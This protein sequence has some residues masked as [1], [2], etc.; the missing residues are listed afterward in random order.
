MLKPILLKI[1]PIAALWTSM[2]L[3]ANWP[4][5]VK[6]FAHVVLSPKDGKASGTVDFAKSSDGLMVRA[7][8]THL[9]PGKH[10]FH[11]HEKGDCSAKDASSAG[12]HYNPTHAKHG[13]P[14]HTE[15]HVGDFGNIVADSKGSATVEVTL[16]NPDSK[17]FKNWDDILGKSIILHEKEDDLNSQPAG[18]SGKRIACGVIQALPAVNP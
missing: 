16:K 5:H 12:D 3:L 9:T 11:I 18:N 10:G 8:L 17:E 2:T 7:Y 4:T 14:S 13:D 1:S 15:R 6:P